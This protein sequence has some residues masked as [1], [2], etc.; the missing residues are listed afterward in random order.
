MYEIITSKEFVAFTIRVGKLGELGD[1]N[2]LVR[3]SSDDFYLL[4]ED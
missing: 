1:T 3:E 2:L 4:K